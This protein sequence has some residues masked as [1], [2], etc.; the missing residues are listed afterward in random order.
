MADTAPRIIQAEPAHVIGQKRRERRFPIP[1]WPP[2]WHQLAL[3]GIDCHFHASA[4]DIRIP[5][6]GLGELHKFADSLDT[7]GMG[8]GLYPT[9]GFIHFDYRAPGEPSYRWTDTSGHSGKSMSRAYARSR[10]SP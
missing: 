9:G 6:V 3:A 5:G 1:S 4:M 2:A 7:G 10:A 8:L